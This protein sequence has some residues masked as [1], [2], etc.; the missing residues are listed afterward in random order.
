MGYKDKRKRKNETL[1]SRPNRPSRHPHSLS[2]YDTWAP[3]T[4]PS[5][6][7][8]SSHARAAPTRRP[9][10]SVEL[11]DAPVPPRLPRTR[12]RRPPLPLPLP[13]SLFTHSK[14]RPPLIAI[15]GHRTLLSPALPLL[16]FFYKSRPLP[17]LSPSPRPLSLSLP[18]SRHPSP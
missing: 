14:Q 17:E 5:P 3:P 7:P 8:T 10:S 2:I 18:L 16:L 11:P 12:N 1:V 15:D 13:H 4:T 6:S 9:R